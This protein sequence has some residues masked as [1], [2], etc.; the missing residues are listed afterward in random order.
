MPVRQPLRSQAPPS[1]TSTL[2]LGLTFPFK[3]GSSQTGIINSWLRVGRPK[4][5]VVWLDL[6]KPRARQKSLPQVSW[7]VTSCQQNIPMTSCS[8]ALPQPGCL[9]SW[10]L[11]CR[12]RIQGVL[13]ACLSVL[14]VKLFK[15]CAL[16]SILWTFQSVRNQRWWQ[17]QGRFQGGKYTASVICRF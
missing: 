17:K 14:T 10:W 3:K 7:H 6:K 2:Y 5:I 15:L 11:S 1:E 13:F 16:N 4:I 8:P 12:F 9:Q